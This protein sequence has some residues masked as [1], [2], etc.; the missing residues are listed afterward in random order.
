MAE[1]HSLEPHIKSEMRVPYDPPTVFGTISSV[2]KGSP[3]I[4]Q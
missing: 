1:P 3:L 4:R 2:V